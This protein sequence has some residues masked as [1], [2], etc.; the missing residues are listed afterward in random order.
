MK[1][2]YL[3]TPDAAV[4]PLRALVDAGFDVLLVV[5]QPDRRRGRGPA[6]APSP[7]KA[8]A[9]ALGIPV[10]ERVAVSTGGTTVYADLGAVP[11]VGWFESP[12]PNAFAT[13]ARRDK[14]L[15]AVSTGLMQRMSRSEVEAVL[16]HEVSHV[17]NGDMVTLTLIQG[18]VNTFVFVISSMANAMPSRPTPDSFTPPNGMTS[19]R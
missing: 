5:T 7:V 11:E 10:T 17:A 19:T 12:S 13:G 1:L 14:S 9:L 2:V 3:G 6:T 15:V 18:V 8:A 16:G 4:P